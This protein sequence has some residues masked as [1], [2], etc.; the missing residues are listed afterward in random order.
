MSADE[1]IRVMIVDDHSIVRV[2]LKQV[3]EQSREI[4]G[5]GDRRWMARRQSGWPPTCRRTWW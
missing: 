1:R 5:G 3:L 2:G 4:R